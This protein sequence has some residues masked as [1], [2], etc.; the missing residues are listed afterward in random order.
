MN[1]RAI[2]TFLQFLFFSFVKCFHNFKTSRFDNVIVKSI[3]N[4]FD[5]DNIAD[6]FVNMFR[7]K[8]NRV[9]AAGSIAMLSLINSKPSKAEDTKSLEEITNKVYFDVAIDGQKKG[10]I[11][12]GLFGK[13]VPKTVENF[14]SLCTGEKGVGESGKKLSYTGSKFHRIIP[15]FMIQGIC[16]QFYKTLLFQ[17]NFVNL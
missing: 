9:T 3:Y 12:I 14:R 8:I 1:Q 6:T 4:K 2:A 17:N 15:R 5:N 10:R 11:V 16:R 7:Q 13:T